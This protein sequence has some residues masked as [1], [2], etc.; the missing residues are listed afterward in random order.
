MA[1]R[2]T[3]VPLDRWQQRLEDAAGKTTHWQRVAVLGETKSTQDHAR[4][5][6]PGAV[7]IAWR[8]TQGR[9][10]LGRLWLD[11]GEE[12]L[13]LSVTLPAEHA[14]LVSIA[15]GIGAAEAVEETCRESGQGTPAVGLKWPND[16]VLSHRK[17]GGILAEVQDGCLTLG[18]GINCAQ[19]E[20]PAPLESTAT[21]LTMHGFEVDR[22]DLAVHLLAHLD[23]WLSASEDQVLEGFASRDTL[24]GRRHRFST[25]VGVVEGIAVRVDPTRGLVVRTSRGDVFLPA[26]TSSVFVD[27][28]RS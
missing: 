25:A 11:T 23:R 6:G 1:A 10:R 5:L 21:S 15:A 26:N 13:A 2:S 3:P 22:I 16:L 28:D 18:I 7:V 8:Q 20:F 19:R 9:G 17:V 12:G 24:K 14:A 27:A 4:D